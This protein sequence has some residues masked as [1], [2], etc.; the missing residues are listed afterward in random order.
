MAAYPKPWMKW[1]V[2]G[3]RV[4]AFGSLGVLALYVLLGLRVVRIPEG[5]S[6]MEPAFS[7]GQSV[8]LKPYLPLTRLERGDVVVFQAAGGLIIGRVAGLPGEALTL[9][10]GKLLADGQDV[11]YQY[12][13]IEVPA[14]AGAEPQ[15]AQ[16]FEVAA[17]TLL[18]LP[19]TPAGGAPAASPWG[20]VPEGAVRGVV[21]MRF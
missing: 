3:L 19:D 7:G 8:L 9:A 5:F 15:E 20:L 17:N 1:L 11:G 14:E 10:A 21:I 4:V 12:M 6:A 2:T 16:R 18:L 13:N